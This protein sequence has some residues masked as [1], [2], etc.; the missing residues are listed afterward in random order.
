M[1]ITSKTFSCVDRNKNIEKAINAG[2]D[3]DYI[4]KCVYEQQSKREPESRLNRTE[5]KQLVHKI[6]YDVYMRN[7]RAAGC[8]KR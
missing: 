8:V 5:C 6:A 7:L 4:T 2:H 3:K 1:Q